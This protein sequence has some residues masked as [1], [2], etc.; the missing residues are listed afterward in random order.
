LLPLLLL[1]A[2]VHASSSLGVAGEKLLGATVHELCAA[3]EAQ[4]VL[5]TACQ[6]GDNLTLDGFRLA[7]LHDVELSRRVN[8]S[9][10]E[11]RV[12]EA[13]TRLAEAKNEDDLAKAA[14]DALL[15]LPPWV[16]RW[17]LDVNVA[18]PVSKEANGESHLQ[19]NGDLTVGY[20][21]DRLGFVVHGDSS[22]FDLV[23]ARNTALTERYAGNADFWWLF[24]VGPVVR[25]EP[26]VSAGA[27]YYGTLADDATATVAVQ[28]NQDS[29]FA[30]GVGSLGARVQPG[31]RVAFYASLG[32]GGQY[33]DYFRVVQTSTGDQGT[34]FNASTTLRY[35]ARVRAQAAIVPGI[36]SFRARADLNAFDM[37]RADQ[38]VTFSLGKVT[39]AEQ[40]VT[41]IAQLE[42][43]ARGFLDADVARFFGFVPAVHGGVNAFVLSS[44]GASASAVVPVFGIGIRREAL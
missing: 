36:L 2:D 33:E 40:G 11:R 44:N 35:E 38:A 8:I 41:D 10:G 5:N 25:L 6:L 4:T 43:V 12:L 17:V 13:A 42:L 22:Y 21:G 24:D 30:R 3:Q 37:R 19:L 23:E 32:L 20:N 26:R 28:S 16:D 7:V 18:P 15:P 27:I 14:R 1:T 29:I 39:L 34:V 31:S 9:A